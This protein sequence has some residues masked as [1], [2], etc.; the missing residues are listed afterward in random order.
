MLITILNYPHDQESMQ[1]DGLSG[2]VYIFNWV[3][4]NGRYEYEPKSVEETEDI[5]LT[6]GI[7]SIFYFSAA[8][9]GTVA[10][11]AAPKVPPPSMER[12]YYGEHDLDECR[13]LCANVGINVPPELRDHRESLLF[14][15]DAY[16]LGAGYRVVHGAPAH[17]ELKAAPQSQITVPR[18]PDVGDE[19]PDFEEPAKKA[20]GPR[21]KQQAAVR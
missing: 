7:N 1:V 16:Y 14:L 8:D 12:K 13:A 18:D 6:Q 4:K 15:L 19:M 10:G 21:R 5:F 3:S 11:P 2:A 17:P 20:T 9:G